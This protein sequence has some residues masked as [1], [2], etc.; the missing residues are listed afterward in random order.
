MLV[1]ILPNIIR[2]PYIVTNALTQYNEYKEMRFERRVSGLGTE[3]LD[4][5]VKYYCHFYFSHVVHGELDS[6]M[7][8]YRVNC[9]QRIILSKCV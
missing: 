2:I 6:K 8:K 1:Y 3:L 9:I 7:E 5:Y 4:L